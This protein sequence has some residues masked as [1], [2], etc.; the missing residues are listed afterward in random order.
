MEVRSP[1]GFV[2]GIQGWEYGEVRPRSIT[3]FTDGTT[4]VVDHRGN[5]ISEYT[6]S[7]A[8]VIARLKDSGI[9]WQKLDYAGWPQLPYEELKELVKLPPTPLD[10]LQKIANKELRT[11]A[12]RMRRESDA[13]AAEE[14]E[15]ATV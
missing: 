4:R 9:D 13:A 5:A 3:F 11:D 8:S 1:G 6:G 12:M 15:L 10:E 7:H 14:A 2:F